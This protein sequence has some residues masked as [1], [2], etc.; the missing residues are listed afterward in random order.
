VRGSG[1][2]AAAAGG[3]LFIA[4]DAALAADR[5]V[6]PFDAASLVIM[7]TYVAAQWLIA[8][9]IGP[10]RTGLRSRRRYDDAEVFESRR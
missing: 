8:A 5:F 4:S 3:A 10:V 1:P 9:S 6:A 2:A 7:G